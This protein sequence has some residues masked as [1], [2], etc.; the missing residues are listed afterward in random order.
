M[1]KKRISYSAD[2]KAKIVLELLEGDK[3]VNELASQHSLLPK[4]IKNWKT[5]FLENASLAFDKST[6]VKE[7][8][9]E[10]VKLKKDKDATSKKL[11]EVIVERDFVVG[12]LKSLVSCKTRVESVDTKLEMGLNKQLSLMSISKT[13]Y[14][15]KPVEKFSSDDDKKMLN[16]IDLIHTKHPYYGTRRIVKILSRIGFKIGRKRIKTAM[17]FMGIKALYPKRKTTIANKYHKKYPYLLN[18][19]KNENKQ[20]V[21][22]TPNKVWSSDITYIRLEHGYAYLAAIIDWHSKKILAWKLSSTMDVSLTTSVLNEALRLYDKPDIFNSDQGSQYTAKAHIDILSKNE[23]S[24]SMDAK[25][26]SI[27]NIVIERFWRTLKYENVYP[28]S[29]SGMKDARKGIREYI[30]IY[31]AERLH[32][33]L[34]YCTPDE[35]YYADGRYYDAKDMLQKV[36]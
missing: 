25:G 19:F 18:E 14:Y 1:S 30:D 3:T 10:I 28:S 24:I 12:K 34:D 2:F 6:V 22:D 27:D 17:E 36:A 20:V 8:K 29:Y 16:T 32:S 31:N 13:A 23:I 7:Y 11:G 21:I 4:N 15:Y 26:R 5:M 33:S 9:E 35:I